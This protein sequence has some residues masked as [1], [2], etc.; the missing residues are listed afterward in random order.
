MKIKLTIATALLTLTSSVF[1]HSLQ[2]E[3]REVKSNQGKILA[4]LFNGESNYQT[5][6][7]M[8]AQQTMAKE[9]TLIVT[10]SNL[11]NGEYAIRYFHDENND[12]QLATNL[13][14]I[15]TEG[16]GYSN[17][18]KGNFGPA[19]YQDMKVSIVDSDVTTHST[20]IY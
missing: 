20:V 16:Y 5:N 14:G 7:P 12:N 13:I 17:N 3:I 9:G 11:E 4:Q 2:L 6:N 8:M 15:P 10:F 19:K 1:S 18:A